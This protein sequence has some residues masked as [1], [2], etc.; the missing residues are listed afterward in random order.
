MEDSEKRVHRGRAY[1]APVIAEFEQT[2]ERQPGF[3]QRRELKLCSFR[4]WLYKIR[5]EAG[6][7]E[8]ERTS[9][10]PLVAAKSPV[11]SSAGA[12]RVM[13]NGVE[14][15]FAERPPGAYLAELLR[16]VDPR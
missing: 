7:Q 8:G 16:L 14:V 6:R 1:W 2:N 10:V 5:R 3:C 11:T 15:S 9:F 4:Q 13:F 12:C